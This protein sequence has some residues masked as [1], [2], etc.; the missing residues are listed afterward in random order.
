MGWHMG[1]PQGW[2][3]PKP[4]M[5]WTQLPVAHLLAGAILLH[6]PGR[7]DN[8][9]VG[10]LLALQAAAAGVAAPVLVTG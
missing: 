2:Q 3:P 8:G 5:G 1:V 6:L 10:G 7:D 4:S 9:E